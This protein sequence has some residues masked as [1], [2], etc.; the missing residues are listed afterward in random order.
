M[1]FLSGI[2]NKK[3]A[4]PVKVPD[5]EFFH[6]VQ[7]MFGDDACRKVAETFEGLQLPPP[8]KATEYLSSLDGFIVFLNEFG[9]VLRIEI[10]DSDPDRSAIA[11]RVENNPFILSPLLSVNAGSATVEIC[12]GVHQE[13]DKGRIQDTADY[14]KNMDY[15]FWDRKFSNAGRLPVKTPHFPEGVTVVIDRG[16]VEDLSESTRSVRELLERVFKRDK[17]RQEVQRAQKELYQPIKKALALLWKNRGDASYAEAAWSLCRRYVA[18]GK[19]V[20][21]WTAPQSEEAKNEKCD[22]GDNAKTPK[23]AR[24]S[25]QYAASHA[26]KGAQP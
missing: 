14:L 2:F 5:T 21:G 1:S 26:S 16:A 18:E 15:R 7:G 12:A 3:A 20:A 24:V 25:A 6:A 13:E 11:D 9:I 23:A 10:S 17:I 19:L 8:V 22:F 4:A